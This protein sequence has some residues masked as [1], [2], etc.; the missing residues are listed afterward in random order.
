MRVLRCTPKKD[1][2]E[3]RYGNAVENR[4]GGGGRVVQPQV[5]HLGEINELNVRHGEVFEEGFRQHRRW[6]LFPKDRPVEIDEQVV[7]SRLKEMGL[8]RPR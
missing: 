6:Y 2:E 5:L 3:Y 8:G 1:V 4:G 7:Q